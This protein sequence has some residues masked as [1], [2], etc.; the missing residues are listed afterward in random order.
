M[1][2]APATLVIPPGHAL[3]IKTVNDTEAYGIRK[4]FLTKTAACKADLEAIL[5]HESRKDQQQVIQ[6]YIDLINLTQKESKAST[7]AV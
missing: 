2:K 6:M 3:Y 4:P 1:V 7:A 5:V